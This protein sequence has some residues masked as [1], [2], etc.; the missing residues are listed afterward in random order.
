M[1]KNVA[2]YDLPSTESLK[3]T[4]ERFLPYWNQSMVPLL[5]VGRKP[6]IAA[7]GNTLRALVKYLEGSSDAEISQLEIPTGIPLV[8][9]LNDGLKPLRRYYL[10]EASDALKAERMLEKAIQ[11]GIAGKTPRPS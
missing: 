9:E 7:H 8:Y 1:Y 3:D 6:I 5:R 11:K 10:G 4:V 2:E